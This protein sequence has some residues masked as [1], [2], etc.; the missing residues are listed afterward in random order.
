MPRAE[1]D[2]WVIQAQQQP[3]P[4]PNQP[5]PPADGAVVEV[6]AISTQAG[7]DPS[8][9]SVPADQPF[10]VNLT[11][12][13]PVV[14]HDFAIA[15]FDGQGNNW[16]GDPDAPGGGSAT[17]NAPAVAAGEYEFYCSIHPN[18]TGTLR[19]E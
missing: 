7:F 8:E 17:Y 10:T 9:L 5:S 19:A 2:Q 12:A 11:N 16:Q 15:D 14:P 3:T 18:M 1:F 4:D 13:D 6:T